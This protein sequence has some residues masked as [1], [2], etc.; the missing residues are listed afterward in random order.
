MLNQI[1]VHVYVQN[2]C[3]CH[4]TQVNYPCMYNAHVYLA[5]RRVHV[6]VIVTMELENVML[7]LT[8]ASTFFNNSSLLIHFH[9]M[10]VQTQARD[11]ENFSQTYPYTHFCS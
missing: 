6:G 7:R 2:L 11:Q 1:N 5:H 8:R 3:R 10:E 4:M 9:C